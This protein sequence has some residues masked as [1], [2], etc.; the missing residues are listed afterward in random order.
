VFSLEELA[1]RAAD[2]RVPSAV[3]TREAYPAASDATIGRTIPLAY[4][5]HYRAPAHCVDEAARTFCLAGHPITRLVGAYL[6]R[7]PVAVANV[8]LDAATFDV[9]SWDGTGEVL[10]DFEGVSAPDGSP[11]RNPADVVRDLLELEAG[12]PAAAFDAESFAA[13][14][15]SWLLGTDR[16]GR[17]V[18]RNPVDLYLDTPTDAWDAVGSVLLAAFGLCYVGAAGTYVLRRWRPVRRPDAALELRDA[19][20]LSVKREASERDGLTRV[21][22]TYRREAGPEEVQTVEALS[23]PARHLLG[24]GADRTMEAEIPTAERS[25]ARAWVSRMLAQ[26]AGRLRFWKLEVGRK[27]L[28]LLPGEAVWIEGT[29]PGAET[30]RGLFEV[31]TVVKDLGTATAE[32]LVSDFRGQAGRSAF[33]MDPEAVFPDHLDGGPMLP[34]SS[35]WTDAQKEWAAHGGGYVTDRHGFTE[36]GAW[37]RGACVS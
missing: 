17:E 12:E 26:R 13:A 16:E 28:A 9:P 15:A 33:V 21:L 20:I 30:L 18:H 34:W 4:G 32:L 37:R 11:M 24:L 2:S 6:S 8:D 19:D 1:R 3:F 23:A 14:R 35:E 7:E 5:L 10:A 25:S 36:P 31:L 22:G 29:R 27:A